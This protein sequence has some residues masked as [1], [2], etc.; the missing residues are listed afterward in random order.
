MESVSTLKGPRQKTT[1]L[2]GDLAPKPRE[3]WLYIPRRMHAA[4]ASQHAL[5]EEAR[6]VA[7]LLDTTRTRVQR[8]ASS[9]RARIPRSVRPTIRVDPKRVAVESVCEAGTVHGGLSFCKRIGFD[10]A[11]QTAGLSE[12]TRDTE[13]AIFRSAYIADLSSN[14]IT[15]YAHETGGEDDHRDREISMD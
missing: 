13:R 14:L 7:E 15:S 12:R 1:C 2:C 4:L 10:A 11:L 9:A 5:F 8:C 3:Q 6:D